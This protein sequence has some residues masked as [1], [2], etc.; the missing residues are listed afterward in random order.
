MSR[1]KQLLAGEVTHF[2]LNTPN[3]EGVCL[4]I[5]FGTGYGNRLISIDNN[6]RWIGSGSSNILINSLKNKIKSLYPSIEC[7]VDVTMDTATLTLK[8]TVL[9]FK[10][11]VESLLSLLLSKEIT[12]EEFEE[13][14]ALSYERFTTHLQNV[15]FRSLM[16][17][18]QYA[19]PNRT[20]S[21]DLIKQD[22][23]DVS[24]EDIILLS[25]T[26][27]KPINTVL[28]ICGND[29]HELSQAINAKS[30]TFEQEDAT[31]AYHVYKQN[32]YEDEIITKT[33]TNKQGAV[34][35][36]CFRNQPGAWSLEEEDMYLLIISDLLVEKDASV[37][38]AKDYASIVYSGYESVDMKKKLLECVHCNES[39]FTKAVE[40]V[41][42][43]LRYL[44]EKSPEV[45][46]R[47]FGQHA[48][49]GKNLS[50]L[51]NPPKKVNFTN[52]INYINQMA[53]QV[54]E[55]K[56]VYLEGVK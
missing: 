18:Q 56:I 46:G 22:L 31:S 21:T 19:I 12:A 33:H 29:T 24:Y 48:I 26:L 1:E 20:Y 34:G 27:F 28:V 42:L 49:Q 53:P 15:T 36:L 5:H 44:V 9:E 2:F 16:D 35:T 39:Q 41:Q 6:M 52:F 4:S 54:R 47:L 30:L 8:M 13:Q 43:K 51:L 11:N 10:E 40:N 23:L 32:V 50:Q 7:H 14:K 55:T 3:Q 37:H 25:N 17:I 38:V 45:F